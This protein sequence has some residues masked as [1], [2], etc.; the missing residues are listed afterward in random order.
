M[1]PGYAGRSE[2]PDNL[3]V[4]F[5]P[6]AM[7]IPDYYLIGEV[8]L[9]SKGFFNASY[10]AKKIVQTYKLCSDQVRCP[11]V[12]LVIKTHFNLLCLLFLPV[13]LS[14]QSHYD[15][16]MRAVKSVLMAA[17]NLKLKYTD[18]Q[19]ELLVLRS[20]KDVNLPKVRH[21]RPLSPP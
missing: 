15:Y 6:V 18:E 9:Y 4:L 8:S 2:L 17:G 1:N 14:S 12:V 19:E 3:K 5:R 10:L 7:I 21:T 11:L 20:I 13:K 16:G